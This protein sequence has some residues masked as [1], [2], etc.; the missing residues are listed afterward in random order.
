MDIYGGADGKTLLRTYDT[1]SNVALSH[2]LLTNAGKYCSSG[3]YYTYKIVL[4]PKTIGSKL[5]TMSSI[6]NNTPYLIANIGAK[7]LTTFSFKDSEN[8]LYCNLYLANL[9]TNLKESFMSCTN[10]IWTTFPQSMSSSNFYAIL[11]SQ[12]VQ[13]YL[14][15]FALQSLMSIN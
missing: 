9:I 15:D 12:D 13:I 8:L 4:K 14:G 7:G 2:T 6:T 10:L 3:G 11:F 5:L 1:T